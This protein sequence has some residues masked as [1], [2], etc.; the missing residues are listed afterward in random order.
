MKDL[1]YRYNWAINNKYVDT[2]AKIGN[3]NPSNVIE[4]RRALEWILSDENDWYN[5]QLNA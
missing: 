2:N 3:L 5:L 1:Y 4:R